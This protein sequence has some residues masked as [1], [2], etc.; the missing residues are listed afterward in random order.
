MK[1]SASGLICPKCEQPLTANGKQ[2]QC[3]D[4]HSYDTAKQGY[5]K[6][7]KG[8]LDPQGAS[9]P[10]LTN[11]GRGWYGEW[12]RTLGAFGPSERGP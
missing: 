3:P 1:D 2:W 7:G 12:G 9:E 5:I 11:I 8:Q 10:I 6:V 4:R